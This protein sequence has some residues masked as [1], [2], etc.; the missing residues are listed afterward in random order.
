M[1]VSYDTIKELKQY[2]TRMHYKYKIFYVYIYEEMCY[3]EQI[4]LSKK[5]TG[6]TCKFKYDIECEYKVTEDTILND[7]VEII[8]D[9]I[10][11]S[12]KI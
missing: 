4:T 1:Y 12:K 9:F 7:M 3:V 5:G 8:G 10:G 11:K 2:L 6:L